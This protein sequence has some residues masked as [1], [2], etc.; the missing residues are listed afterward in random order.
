MVSM[1]QWSRPLIWYI[2]TC[3]N[4]DMKISNWDSYQL[5]WWPAWKIDI[6]REDP[7]STEKD[8]WTFWSGRSTMVRAQK[9]KGPNNQKMEPL[10]LQ[11]VA[12][13]YYIF[14]GS[15]ESSTN[16]F[17]IIALIPVEHF[18][19]ILLTRTLLQP[20]NRFITHHERKEHSRTEFTSDVERSV[21]LC[22]KL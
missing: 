12:W 7:R 21:Y 19:I 11:I 9:I 6:Y 8:N 17:N 20:Q 14:S 16:H 10:A 15:R 1:A 18:N 22:I 5:N 2:L 4:Q 13:E 3:M